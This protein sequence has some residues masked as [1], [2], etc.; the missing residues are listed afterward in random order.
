MANTSL[1]MD[2][3][4]GIETKYGINVYPNPTTELIN[5]SITSLS[6]GE[7]AIVQLSDQQGKIL[8]E[9]KQNSP[10]LILSLIEQKAGTYSIKVFIKEESVS[11]KIVKF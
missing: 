4:A 1:A 7:I 5:V 9:K 10:M 6:E 2:S 11:Y 8:A 3:S